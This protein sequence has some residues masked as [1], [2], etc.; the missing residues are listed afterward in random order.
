MKL[1]ILHLSDIHVSSSCDPILKMGARI[2][3]AGFASLADTD[4]LLIV[5]SGDIANSGK[6]EEYCLATQLLKEIE[7]EITKE[8]TSL[9]VSFVIVPGNHDCN[10]SGDQRDRN[11]IIDKILAARNGQEQQNLDGGIFD[12][13]IGVQDEFEEFRKN[14]CHYQTPIDRLWITNTYDMGGT[15]VIVDGINLSWASQNPESVGKIYFPIRNYEN[16]MAEECAIRIAVF[17]HP[18]HWLSQSIYRDFRSFV[19]RL[20]N[21]VLTG[22]EHRSNS[23]TVDESDSGISSFVEAGALQHHGADEL[24]DT[25]FSIIRMCGDHGEALT[26]QQFMYDE[27]AEKYVPSAS[28][29]RTITSVRRSP[30]Q[31]VPEFFDLLEDVVTPGAHPGRREVR[32]SDVFEFPML[33]ALK[34]RNDDDVGFFSSSVFAD[35]SY[36]TNPVVLIGSENAGKTSLLY[37]LFKRLL[38]SGYI[39]VYLDASRV[40]RTDTGELTKVVATAVEEQFG[41]AAWLEYQQTPRERKR[42]LLDNIDDSPIRSS[43]TR[44]QALQALLGMFG[45]AVITAPPEFAVKEA[46]SDDPTDGLALR[47]FRMEPFG[48]VL[49]AKLVEKWMSAHVE[50]GAADDMVLKK[51]DEAERLLSEVT[52]NNMVPSLPLFLITLLQSLDV[53]K[54]DDLRGAGLGHYYEYLLTEHFLAAGAKREKFVELYSYTGALAWHLHQSGAREISLEALRLFNERYSI[55]WVKTDCDERLEFLLRAKVIKIAGDEISFKYEFIY[56]LMKAKHMSD[57]LED[58]AIREHLEAC[59]SAL[60]VRDNAQTVL[61]LSHYCIDGLL[62]D[63]VMRASRCAFSDQTEIRFEGDIDP[64]KQLIVDSPKLVLPSSSPSENRRKRNEHRDQLDRSRGDR[65]A[66]DA[67]DDASRSDIGLSLL[68][69]TS[70][71]IGQLLKDQYSRIDRQRKRELIKEVFDA[72]M[73]GVAFVYKFLADLPPILRSALEDV[74]AATKEN[75]SKRERLARQAVSLLVQVMTLVFISRAADSARSDEIADDIA[76]V[77]RDGDNNAYYL[78][79]IAI[80]LDRQR[81]L[82]RSKLKDLQKRFDGNVIAERLL[83]WLVINRLMMFISSAADFQWAVSQFKLSRAAVRTLSNQSQGLTSGDPAPLL[84]A[85]KVDGGN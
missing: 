18:P 77:V 68:F 31:I 11:D 49:R 57:R 82:P 65:T 47:Q 74:G 59:C 48:Y 58:A 30:F 76:A 81:P 75:E 24:R 53:G 25:G 83:R 85:A 51:R 17:H 29:K 26:H 10:L 46:L 1:A 14:M 5:I 84:A 6:R 8:F 13:C 61:F 64:I 42:L 40:K 7:S 21:V 2:A 37:Q 44:A 27:A 79:D 50:E 9:E 54:Q 73:R 15:R 20:A 41:R 32:L 39:P 33:K 72:P 78:V 71:I 80:E 52:G 45:G 36:S 70:E 3:R 63:Q 43:K 4:R 69:K 34:D 35:A 23:G 56:F 62:L 28:H 22:H 66:E 60:H 19:R 38:E 55:D 16:K 12:I 67:E